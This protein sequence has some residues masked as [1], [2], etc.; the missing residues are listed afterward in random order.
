[1]SDLNLRS[2]FKDDYRIVEAMRELVPLVE[3]HERVE[4]AYQLMWDHVIQYNEPFLSQFEAVLIKA[5]AMIDTQGKFT[6]KY[7]KLIET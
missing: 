4:D 6:E 7:L 3:V 5:G 1:M 2:W